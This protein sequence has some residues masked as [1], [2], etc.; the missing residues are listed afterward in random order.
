[1][2]VI[3]EAGIATF[4]NIPQPNSLVLRYFAFVRERGGG[5]LDYEISMLPLSVTGN[6]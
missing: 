4:T 5:G 2:K 6:L 1:M 3:Q